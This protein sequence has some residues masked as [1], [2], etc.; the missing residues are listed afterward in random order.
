VPFCSAVINRLLACSHIIGFYRK[1]VESQNVELESQVTVTVVFPDS[2]LPEPTDGGFADQ[3]EFRNYVMRNQKDGQW[4][5]A[6][7]CR[8]MAEK[9]M[10]Y[11][12]E[13]IAMAFPLQFPYG[14]SG[15]P[16]DPAVLALS[17]KR[18]WKTHVKRGRDKRLEE[19]L[20][21]RNPIFHTPMFCLIVQS[22]LM[23]SSIFKSSRIQCNIKSGEGIAMA[24]KYVMVCFGLWPFFLYLY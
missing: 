20:Q 1:D 24:A 18:G 5:S 4:D 11:N 23:K 6:L 19:L 2:S 8:P 17:E 10:D 9:L 12:D 16:D 15:L 3:Q 21:H 13:A 22:T 7:H 14:H